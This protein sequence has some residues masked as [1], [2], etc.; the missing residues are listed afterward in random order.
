MSF[1]AAVLKPIRYGVR[2]AAPVNNWAFATLGIVGSSPTLSGLTSYATATPS[3]AISFSTTSLPSPFVDSSF[4]LLP[5]AS[6]K[7]ALSADSGATYTTYSTPNASTINGVAYGSGYYWITCGTDVYKSTDC[8]AWTAVTMP[9]VR[10]R[11]S[12]ATLGTIIAIGSSNGVITKSTDGGASWANITLSDYGTNSVQVHASTNCIIAF[13]TALGRTSPI[14]L[15]RTTD[16]NTWTAITNPYNLTSSGWAIAANSGND[17][18]IFAGNQAYIKSADDGLTWTKVTGSPNSRSIYSAWMADG[19]WVVGGSTG[20]VNYSNDFGA[21]WTEI[22]PTIT[23]TTH[24][25][26][27][28]NP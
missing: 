18:M 24:I 20:Y 2:V 8:V 9:T 14:N 21:S 11:Y 19:Y 17:W 3:P 22:R 7:Y 6:A 5:A 27:F 25:F 16:G 28:S 23:Q 4:I 26:A 12:I 15:R 10:S 13:P 1:S